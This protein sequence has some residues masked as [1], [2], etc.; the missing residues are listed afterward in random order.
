M[1]ARMVPDCDFMRGQQAAELIRGHQADAEAA[2]AM[3]V[4]SKSW[5]ANRKM[6]WIIDRDILIPTV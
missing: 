5:T 6:P 3:A 4:D 1:V 2:D